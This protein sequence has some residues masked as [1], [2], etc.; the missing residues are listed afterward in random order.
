MAA[1]FAANCGA[2]R[3]VLTHFSARYSTSN[4]TAAAVKDSEAPSTESGVKAKAK[5]KAKDKAKAL[6]QANLMAV[7]EAESP[8]QSKVATAKF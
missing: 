7:D 3:L 6:S 8:G 5:D 4:S 2:Q 1:Q